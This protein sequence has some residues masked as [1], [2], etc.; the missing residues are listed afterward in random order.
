MGTGSNFP[1][2]M[3]G[4]HCRASERL[5]HQWCAD[6]G[7]T[8]DNTYAL[9]LVSKQYGCTVQT[10]GWDTTSSIAGGQRGT[11]KTVTDGNGNTT[12]LSNWKRGIP[13]TIQYPATLEFPSGATQSAQVNDAGWITRATDENGYSTG[14]GYDAMGRLASITYPGGDS[15]A[16]HGTSQVFEQVNA[17]EYGIPAGH[18]RQTVATGNGRKV[19]YFDALWRPLLVREYDTAHQAATQR[20]QRFA[21]DH[22][23]RVTF[24]AYPA[25]VHDSNTGTHTRYDALGRV[26]QVQQDSEL[27]PALLTTR[28]EYLSG[29]KTR[30]TDPKGNQTTSSYMVWDTPVTDFPVHIAHPGGAHTHIQ[31]DIFGKPTRIRRSNS[32][33]PDAGTGINRSYSYNAQQL[34]CRSVEPE[35]GTTLMG[36]DGAGNLKWSASGLTGTPACELHGNSPAVAARRVSRSY[37]ARNRLSQLSFP[38]GRGNQSRRYTPDGLPATITTHNSHGGNTV[39]NSYSHNKR[40]L[41]VQETTTADASSPWTL[42]YGYNANGHLNSHSHPAGLTAHYTLNALGQ[43]TQIIAQD[44]SSVN[45]ASNISYFPNGAVKGFTYGNR[46]R[47]HGGNTQYL[48]DHSGQLRWQRDEQ[49]GQRIRHIYLGNR[50]IA[51]HRKPIGSNTISIEYLHSD[52]Q[53]SPIAKTNSSKTVAFP[54]KHTFQK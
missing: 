20:F 38:D 28:T 11:I 33:N 9:P 40:R 19:T 29:F 50:L 39:T 41:L 27:S 10:L 54:V 18:W 53:G 49:A 31:R 45:V 52:A 22:E 51:E 34:L 2:Q 37:D 14:Y 16:W 46:L 47:S 32:A 13:Q 3:H 5:R 26:V 25:S 1:G 23:G 44:G 6:I 24:A 8:Y 12:T 7:N 15:T 30:V 17:A 42:G 48:Y 43:V 4:A 21:Y 36:Y 35:T